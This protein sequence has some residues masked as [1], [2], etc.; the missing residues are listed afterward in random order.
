[1]LA[2]EILT[3]WGPI[4]TALPDYLNWPE[5]VEGETYLIE[6][7]GLAPTIHELPDTVVLDDAIV[8]T[9]EW[10]HGVWDLLV[11]LDAG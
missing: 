1:M 11:V 9:Q 8:L 2:V 6:W 4:A 5:L 7:T 10:H 3:V